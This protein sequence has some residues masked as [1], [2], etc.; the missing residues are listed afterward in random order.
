MAKQAIGLGST[1]NDGTGDSLRVGG[2][3]INDNFDEIYTTFGDGSTLTP[4]TTGT[5]T[6]TNK[7]INLTSN[8]L[9]GTL[10][11]FNTALSDDDF[12]SLTG[13]ETLTNKTLT[14]VGA[15]ISRTGDLEIDVSGSI[16]LDADT[17]TIFLQDGSSGNYGQFIANYSSGPN[18]TIASGNTTAIIFT[19]TLAAFQG[20][21]T[22]TDLTLSGNLVVN[23]ATT[24]VSSTNTTIADN[25][26]ELNSGASSNANDIGIIMERGSTGDNAIFAWDESE[27]KFT[28]GTTT[29]T[30]DSTGN[31]SITAG[32]L[33]AN[34]F[35]GNVTGDVTGN[36]TGNLTGN[37]TGNVTGTLTG[38]VVGGVAASATTLETARTIGMTGD[39]VWTSASFDG[40]A[41]VTGT[42]TIQAS[43]VENSMIADGA[44]NSSKL[45]S[46][47]TLQILDSSGSAVKTII[48]AGS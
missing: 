13:T 22:A 8:T 46:A 9:S 37:V 23:G 20:N 18:L 40:S 42:A 3:K 1:A 34:T 29:A 14:D 7:T 41:N 47:V 12:A 24:T 32:T 25:M 6:L 35:E 33:V 31:I 48:G 16:L 17:G 27:D 21:I 28:I 2:D 44:I 4:F 19:G 45:T 38:N 39:V 11:Q 15:T 5:S 26:F 10:A 30:A 43:A 36:V